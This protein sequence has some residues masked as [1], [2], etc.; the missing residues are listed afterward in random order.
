MDVLP[1]GYPTLVADFEAPSRPG[2]GALPPD[3]REYRRAG[4][5]KA[6]VQYAFAD[7]PLKPSFGSRT[8]AVELSR[9]AGR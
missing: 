8:L 1:Q 5:R 3:H 4:R 7:D 6:M 2:S 9:S